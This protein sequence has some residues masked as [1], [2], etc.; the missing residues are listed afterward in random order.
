MNFSILTE[1]ANLSVN[2]NLPV[3]KYFSQ[4]DLHTY[5]CQIEYLDEGLKS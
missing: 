3:K 2:T 5:D 1:P 4:Y